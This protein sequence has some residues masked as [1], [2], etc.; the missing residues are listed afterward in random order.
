MTVEEVA[1]KINRTK[2]AVYKMIKE[3]RGIGKHFVYKAGKG[4]VVDG[5]LVR[6]AS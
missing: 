6:S 3:K 2:G 5:R 4:Y 1:K